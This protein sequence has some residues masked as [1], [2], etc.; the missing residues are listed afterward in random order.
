MEAHPDLD[1]DGE[2]TGANPGIKPMKKA[3]KPS[4]P[5]KKKAPA[6]KTKAQVNPIVDLMK[7]MDEDL[8]GMLLQ[9]MQ[10]ETGSGPRLFG[11]DDPVELF[12]EYLEACTQGNVDDDEKNKL[13]AD[14]VEVLDELKVDS[15]GGDPEARGKIQA[16]YD[17]LDNAIEGCSLK[18]PDLMM[19]GKILSD[20]GWAVP[21]SLKQ[22]M[23]EALKAPPP[24]MEGGSG[25]DLV[26]SML[27]VA[28]QVGQNPFAV[29]EYLN[30]FLASFPPEASAM[31]LSELIA[32]KKPVIDQAVAGFLLHPDAVLA[33]TVAEAL[34]ASAGKTPVE[35]SLIERLVLI[36]PWLPQT[37][38]A[39]LDSTIRA[40]R[41]K[42]LPPVKADSL[43]IIK[44]YASACDGSGTRSL[45]V[46]QRVGAHYQIATVMMKP[47]GVADAMVV[48]E[49]SKSATDDIVREMKSCFPVMETDLAGI[50][51]M[52]GLAIA[53]NFTSGNPPPFKLVEVVE[54]IGVGA[55]HPDYASPMEIITG[56]LA[57]L[58]PE[59]TDATA[60]AKAHADLLDS[61][62]AYQWFEA[63]QA[64]EDLLYPVKGSK[65][66][67]VKLMKAY[68]PERRAF[69]ARQCAISALV[70]HN[71]KKTPHSPWKQLA[72]VGRDIA[73]DM[74]LDQIPLMKQI[75]EASARAF[76]RRL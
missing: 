3:S 76:E 67:V 72:L 63:G 22:A 59:Q 60:V 10:K 61:E 24:D 54:C 32:G 36:R 41:L 25:K 43:K 1:K 58:P 73:S 49:L 47:V 16:I 74:P 2:K 44:C 35:S 39:Q 56:L 37:R 8:L 11:P 71:D 6:K 57:D 33:Q 40:M 27:E 46:T 26:S 31:L 64:L 65:Q 4:K 51:R 17:L 75:A 66:R 5:V 9:S 23:T 30:S 21:D 42:A 45:F 38:Q 14:L 48:P 52:L 53:D 20:A 34:A 18:V 29:Y 55:V 19:T 13:L 12:V 7:N 28:D 68:L 70:M 50:T 15:N 69:W 62:F